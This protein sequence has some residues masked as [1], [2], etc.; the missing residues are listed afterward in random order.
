MVPLLEF[1]DTLNNLCG[2]TI[3]ILY[4]VSVGCQ[5]QKLAS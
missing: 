2:Y 5:V 3:N 1:K 4:P